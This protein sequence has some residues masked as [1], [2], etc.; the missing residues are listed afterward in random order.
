MS[1][2]VQHLESL[3]PAPAIHSEILVERQNP[4]FVMDLGTANQAGIRE[5]RR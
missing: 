1:R 2:S 4:R 3:S 5:R